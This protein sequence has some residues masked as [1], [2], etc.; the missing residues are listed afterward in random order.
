MLI[1]KGKTLFLPDSPGSLPF[2]GG[3]RRDQGNYAVQ[4]LKAQLFLN[5]DGENGPAVLEWRD[6]SS[7]IRAGTVRWDRR[8]FP[9]IHLPQT[10]VWRAPRY[11]HSCFSSAHSPAPSSRTTARGH[12]PSRVSPKADLRPRGRWETRGPIGFPMWMHFK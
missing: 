10:L 12:R 4:S 9:F 6:A 5:Q 2:G 8:P 7:V 11:P 1:H 3:L